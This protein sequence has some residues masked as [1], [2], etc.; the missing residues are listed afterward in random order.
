MIPRTIPCGD[1]PGDKVD[2]KDGH[3]Q[4]ANVIFPELM[5]EIINVLE[6]RTVKRIVVTVCGGS[7]AGKSG[8]ASLLSYYLNQEGIGSYTLSGDNYPHRIPKYN[9]AERLRV[10][11]E[12]A[13]QGMLAENTYTGERF[14]IINQLQESGDDANPAYTQE[15]SWY[16]S[17]LEHGRKGLEKYLGTPAEIGFDEIEDVVSRFKA[18]ADQIWLRRMGREDTQ[19]W[20][21]KKDFSKMQVLIIE[22]THGN[23][24]YY[25]GVDIPIL[26]NSTPAETLAYRLMR[27]RDG[28]I[29]SPFTAMV[30]EI[31]QHL[32]QQQAHKAHI[33]V[34]MNAH[35]IDYQEYRTIMGM[36]D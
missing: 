36:R 2:I 28:A 19:L 31:E 4:K 26:L 25:Q 21:D 17:Y 14:E 35:R 27:N 11:R 33:I 15:Y 30:L 13:L 10:Y 16:A 8:V 9:D 32:L 20:Y 24:D 18:G 6:K 12:S 34:T 1:M 5:K 22:W 3:I 29:D 7:G 23:S